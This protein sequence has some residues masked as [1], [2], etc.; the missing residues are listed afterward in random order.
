M[1]LN[2]LLGLWNSPFMMGWY[3]RRALLGLGTDLKTA[4]S[5]FHGAVCD[6][7]L[8]P[9]APLGPVAT[10]GHFDFYVQF[11]SKPGFMPAD[12]PRL[13]IPKAWYVY[14]THIHAAEIATI[15]HLFDLVLCPEERDRE[16]LLSHGCPRVEVLPF[17]AEPETYFREIGPRGSRPHKLGFAGSAKGHPRLEE[18]ARFLRAIGERHPLRVEHRTMSG[19]QVADFYGQCEVVVN[20]AIAGELNMRVPEALMSGATLLTP[21]VEGLRGFVDTEK[22]LCAFTPGD[23]FERIDFLLSHP[24]EAE[25][26]ARHGQCEALAKHTYAHRAR[27][28]LDILADELAARRSR[29]PAPKNPWLLEA[30]MLRY[31]LFQYPGDALAQLQS[32]AFLPAGLPGRLLRALLRCLERIL[33]LLSRL[34]RR[35]YFADQ[36][37]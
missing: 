18:R 17:A 16:R 4:G 32:P 12:L 26:L 13:A 10:R 20:H 25:A 8:E 27:R 6:H 7:P 15:A 22:S 19:G 31:R 36:E 33:R 14:D 37:L 23:V 2:L 28:L 24:A 35:T 30:A 29:P 34:F 21:M 1:G 9:G 3:Y 11:Y 5:G